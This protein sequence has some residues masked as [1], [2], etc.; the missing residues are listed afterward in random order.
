MQLRN[1]T[2]LC[3]MDVSE[4]LTEKIVLLTNDKHKR[5]KN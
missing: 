3:T 5:L 4:I 2:M 1:V